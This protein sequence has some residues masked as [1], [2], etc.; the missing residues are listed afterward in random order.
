MFQVGS[1]ISL[2]VVAQRTNTVG[3]G[4]IAA[5]SWLLSVMVGGFAFRKKLPLLVLIVTLPL[6]LFSAGILYY[7]IGYHIM[8][9]RGLNKP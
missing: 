9:W 4:W 6:S 5:I 3:F 1:A 7:F 8:G 2:T